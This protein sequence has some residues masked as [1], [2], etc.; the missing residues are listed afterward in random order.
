MQISLKLIS[1]ALLVLFQLTPLY[2][3]TVKKVA[4]IG[5]SITFGYGIKDRE[6]NSYPSQLQNRLGGQFIVHNFG[7]SGATLLNKGHNPYTKTEEYQK[8]IDFKPDYAIIH[9]GINDTD[10]RNYPLHRDDFTKD[11]FR[12]IE[13]LRD[14]NPH[15]Q[16]YICQLSPIF[17]NHPRFKSSTLTWYKAI[18]EDIQRVASSLNLPTIDL[19][20]PLYNHP[21]LFED[22]LHPDSKGAAIIA[23]TIY[24]AITG[25]Y[26]GLNIDAIF[27]SNMVLQREKPIT[28]FGTANRESDISITFNGKNYSAIND[29]QGTWR[30]QIPP[31]KAGGPYK[32]S[33]TDGYENIT[34]DNVWIGDVWIAAGQS[35]MA[36][37]VNQSD[38]YEE[39]KYSFDTPLLKLYN[40]QPIAETDNTEWSEAVLNQVN[41]L[42]Y[43]KTTQWENSS[44]HSAPHFSAIGYYFGAELIK[45][46]DI[47]IGIINMAV[48]G[49]TTESWIPRQYMENDPLLINFFDNW[50]QSDYIDSWVKGRAALNTNRKTLKL[51]QHPYHPSYLYES[52]LKNIEQLPIAG[53]IWYQG[54]S[55]AHNVEL[56]EQLFTK[57]ITSW[58]EAKQ[59][60]FPFYFV[61]LSSIEGRDTWPHFRDSQR[62]LAKQ[63]PNCEMVISSDVGTRNDVHPRNKKTVANRIVNLVLS[64]YYGKK[65]TNEKAV[66]P[67]KYKFKG[68]NL[69]ISFDNTKYLNTSDNA[70]IKTLEVAGEDKIFIKAEGKIRRNSILIKSD[71]E[72]LKY[73]RYG[74]TPYSEGNLVNENGMPVSTFSNEF[75]K[76]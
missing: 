44:T 14:A 55:N 56:H 28:L 22:S 61:Q 43:F 40:M 58:R 39:D 67:A 13:S 74:W 20:N 4:C 36:F 9:L 72:N 23:Q 6:V 71:L 51:Q 52:A 62:R 1:L 68:N 32:I 73:V 41:D 21:E 53:V 27:S 24:Q 38:T 7:H 66:T 63:I 48:G 57:L 60:C 69:T 34:C 75:E 42:N 25:E 49:S 47:P 26:G 18:K 59:E 70:P 11:Y 2:A 54:E 8:A 16:I 31:M 12:L 37:R 65:K 50:K 64:S 29:R 3:N 46:Q 30:I 15:V 35:N 10:P 17:P 5:N 45:Q 76:N 33:V 19:Y